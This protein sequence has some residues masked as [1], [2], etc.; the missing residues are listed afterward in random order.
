M[1][2]LS[3]E[4]ARETVKK[5]IETLNDDDYFN[6]IKVSKHF[7]SQRMLA[8]FVHSIVFFFSK[9]G[10]LICQAAPVLGHIT[11]SSVSVQCFVMF[12]LSKVISAEVLKRTEN[13]TCES[14]HLVFVPACLFEDCASTFSE[15]HTKLTCRLAKAISLL[16]SSLQ[17]SLL[18]LK[19]PT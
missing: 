6:V 4:I 9:I 17:Q 1:K 7:T 2:G 8:C 14:S 10:S 15:L 19:R 12:G 18:F 13:V 11:S 3:L 5:I 16:G